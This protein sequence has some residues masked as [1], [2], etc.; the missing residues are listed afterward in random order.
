VHP[1]NIMSTL[2]IYT[3]LSR[4]NL[5]ILAAGF[6]FLA[7]V[8]I[9]VSG[10]EATDRN[11]DKNGLAQPTRS[12]K[13]IPN[14][15]IR[16]DSSS[17]QDHLRKSSLRD[18][19]SA[20]RDT[21]L[22]NK[23]AIE[24]AVDDL[25]REQPDVEI[26]GSALTGAVEIVDS[27][28][29]L[30]R[31]SPNRSGEEIVREFVSNNRGIYGLD[32]GEITN[33]HFIGES[34]SAESGLRMVR[35][36]QII[37]GR[38]VFQ[39]ETRFILD[40][41]GRIVRSLG[42]M[43]PGA[44][45]TAES[46]A[47]LLSPQEAL[48]RTMDWFGVTLEV[49]T[50]KVLSSE[51]D[52]FQSDIGV[53]DQ[54]IA[55]P[56]TS[57]LV[58]FPVAPGVL[59]PAWSQ[60][61]FGPDH[62]WY[63]LVDARDGTQL[64][65]KD[66]RSDASTHQARFRVYVQADGS[67]PADSPAPRSPST[68]VVGAGT[69]FPEILP[70][71]VSMLTVQ[72]LT[73]SPNGWIDDC[74]GGV[75]TVNETQTLGNNTLVCVDRTTGAANVCDSTGT[76]A[77]DGNGRPIGNPDASARNR[78]FLGTAPRDF[79]TDFLPAPQA[80]NP[81]AGT[82]SSVAG[83]V[84]TG[85]LRGSA[86]QQ[87]YVTNWYHDKLF[88]LGFDTAAG[89]FQTNNFGGG[90]SGN[91][92]VLVDVQDGQSSSN[93]NFSTP[94][95]GSSGRAQMFNFLS[96][97]ID[98]DGGLDAEILIHELTHGTSNRLVGNATGLQ[99]DVGAGMGEGWSDF[100]ALSLLNNTNADNPD[101]S[102]AS[103]A[104]A[105]YKLAG[106][107]DNY[108]Y[109][110]R[111]FP[112]STNNAINPLTWADVDQT[113]Y[114]HSGGIAVSPIGFEV[115][116]AMEVHNVGEIWMNTLWEMRSRIIA[117]NGGDVPTGNQI[118][119]QLVTNALKMTP[120]NPTFLQARD[121]LI[122]ADCA[123][124]ACANEG[125]IWNA[126]ADRGLGYNAFAPL[127]VQF[128]IQSGHIGVAEST[129]T[130]N[131]DINTIAITDTIGNSNGFID[132]NEPFRFEI[133]IKNP[134]RHASKTA[135]GVTATISSSTPGVGIL[136]AS[137]TYPDIAPNTNANRNA[138]NMVVQAP[139][140]GTC[141]SRI[142][143]TLTVTSSLG[144]VTRDFSLRIGQPSGTLSP[145][146]YTRSAVGLA[147]PDNA[148]R[149]AIDTMNVPDDYQIADVNVRI[150]SLT[151][152]YDGDVTAGIRGP[153][154][155]GTDLL[156]LTGWNAG[157]VFQNFGSP[158]NN[159][160]NT[161]FDD[162]AA[163]D[164]ISAANATAPY[165]NSYKPAFNSPNWVPLLGA[166]PDATPQL[167]RFDGTSSQGVWKLV[168][169]DSAAP[170]A[171]TLQGWSLIVTPQN[172]VCSPFTPTAAGVSV[173]GR[174][175]DMFGSAIGNVTLTLTDSFGQARITRSSPFGYFEFTDIPIGQTY[176]L[177]AQ[178]KRY[179]FPTQTFSVHDAIDNILLTAE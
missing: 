96:P 63:V 129:L 110:I 137:T 126:F 42:L 84:G 44:S 157:G 56:V 80:G 48:K 146:T 20:I 38:P 106:L 45:K 69:Q 54:N 90:G 132:P 65:R 114:D 123:T 30:T 166:N 83:A 13:R 71:I 109:G 1:E 7:G 41:E 145:V 156:A 173:S 52:G 94:P 99:W 22:A 62:D 142:Q 160:T 23:T 159:F 113:T 117:A 28:G 73:A 10:T 131:L 135:T 17:L 111:R 170:D 138:F 97:T 144:T 158:G 36:E 24:A 60:I 98:R 92:R 178:A 134:W 68:A 6:L 95:D 120:I 105:T 76:S 39:S 77:L 55:G 67:T 4:S 152:T 172:F 179:T 37:N 121:A 33:L 8:L 136:S 58:Y 46:L 122:S 93:A 35:V 108:V 82:S 66:I 78:D 118:A 34:V 151:H 143:F 16:L 155:Y 70:T 119:L 153:N 147:I 61:V 127:A 25:R 14:F 124:N 53:D 47:A 150:D 125:S 133:N 75:C 177:G 149:G 168:V 140:A 103:G 130:P 11:R 3:K 148:G 27:A 171:G 59:V 115:G 29:G 81:E 89:N 100:Y 74:P 116:G 51:D 2:K 165:T 85:F 26:S 161:V 101:S 64:W 87:F 167:T 21:A 139:S 40:S 141:G 19:D 72:S 86:V 162:E 91:D 43:V 12:S 57:K 18:V 104:Y 154:G 174:V 176:L 102:Y 32:E 31:P 169:S 175:V 79:Q 88:L 107:L 15:D 164:L 128:G 49:A 50:M 163:N 112:Y 9:I 5:I